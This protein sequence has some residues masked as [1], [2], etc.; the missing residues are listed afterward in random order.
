MKILGDTFGDND[1]ILDLEFCY[2]VWLFFKAL[3][4]R[5]ATIFANGGLESPIGDP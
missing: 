2:A 1:S 4:G 5:S 3:V